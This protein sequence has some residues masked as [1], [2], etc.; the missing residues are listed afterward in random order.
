MEEHFEDSQAIREEISRAVPFYD[1]I[2]KL[3]A[4]GEAIQWGGARLC[5]GGI[6][7]TAD[8]LAHFTP[9]R[10]PEVNIPEGQFLMS[11]RRG[12]QFNSMVQAERNPLTGARRKDVLMNAEDAAYLGLKHGDPVLVTSE[13]GELRGTCAIMPMKGRNIQVH[14]PEG[15]VLLRL[16]ATDPVCGIP[17]YNTTVRI[18]PLRL[19]RQKV[20][21]GEHHETP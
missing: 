7:P 6:F 18:I 8:H 14:W 2:Q 20:W 21:K 15:N 3:M 10:P 9:L 19:G 1:G 16:G 17:D 11:T 5:E 12:K 4:K 13:A